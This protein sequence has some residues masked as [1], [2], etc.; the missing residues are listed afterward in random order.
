MPR[1]GRA[2]IRLGRLTVQMMWE[3]VYAAGSAKEFEANIIW[4]AADLLGVSS[5]QRVERRQRVSA[6][7]AALARVGVGRPQSPARATST[8]AE[9]RPTTRVRV[10]LSVE[11]SKRLAKSAI[12]LVCAV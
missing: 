10:V 8:V 3:I 2:G 1:S 5:R 9:L 6:D 4:R 7:S 12:S 11:E